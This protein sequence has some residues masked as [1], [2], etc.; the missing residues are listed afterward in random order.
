MKNIALLSNRT[1]NIGHIFMAFGME[2]IAR[3]AFGPDVAITHYEQHCFFDIYPFWH[4]LRLTHLVR[5]GW[6][7]SLREMLSTEKACRY[8]WPRAHAIS[9]HHL[10]VACGGPSASPCVSASP[11][12]KLMF[13]HQMGAF[14]FHGVPAL[15]IG[16]GSGAF[17]IE[18]LPG[19]EYPCFTAGDTSYFARMF[20]VT[21][22]T[23]ARDPFAQKLF[24]E[25]GHDVPLIPCAAIAV[26]RYFQ[27]NEAVSAPGAKYIFINFQKYG[28]NED[29]GQKVDP[30]AWQA[31]VR[32]LIGRLRPRHEVAFLCHNKLE[33][34]LAEKVDAT[35]PRFFPQTPEEYG[36]VIRQAKAGLVSRIH[37]AIPLAGIGIPSIVIGTDTRLGSVEQI[38]LQTHYVKNATA[39]VLEAGL[40]QLLSRSEEEKNRLLAVRDATIRQ[41]AAILRS[42][43]RS[44]D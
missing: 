20:A 35:V 5:H 18:Q 40:E 4:P 42:F 10:A 9:R 41:Y 17:P 12:M 43:A 14:P 37:A 23:T 26:G 24:A 31:T 13:L 3:E 38:G 1:G 7:K 25:L 8:F 2:E 44:G 21:A 16:V 32:N 28:A 6:L 30:E 29:W 11:E 36:Q 19:K 15:N 39:D 27:K 22:Q 34:I 33:R